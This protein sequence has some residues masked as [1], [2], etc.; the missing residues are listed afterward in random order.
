ML[1]YAGLTSDHLSHVQWYLQN[2]ASNY[3]DDDSEISPKPQRRTQHLRLLL[4]YLKTWPQHAYCLP[5]ALQVFIDQV[6][7]DVDHQYVRDPW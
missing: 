3:K 4:S 7:R 2:A 5:I 6:Y 1:L